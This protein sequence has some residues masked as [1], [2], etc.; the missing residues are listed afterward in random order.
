MTP[1]RARR[2]GRRLLRHHLVLAGLVVG[3]GLLVQGWIPSPDPLARASLTSAY[4]ALGLLSATLLT[5]P[6]D[7]LRG[8]PTPV[9]TDLRRDIGIWA[10]VVGLVHVVLGLQVH[11][12]GRWWLYFVYGPQERRRPLQS[13]VRLDPFGLANHTG[14]AATL[15]L[16][17]LLAISNDVALRRLGSRRW[18]S[19]Q[20]WN[21]AAAAL[22]LGH[23]FAYQFVERRGGW[24]VTTVAGVAGA[25]AA[26]QLLGYRRRRRRRSAGA[27]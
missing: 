11:L 19:V 6:L 10:A 3:G 18:K 23:G 16:L 5:G 22:V 2:L 7:V 14:L 12:R 26:I 21:Y 24:Y 17:V 15:L 13:P 1:V 9:S 25:T 27:S 20:R 4:V 8:R